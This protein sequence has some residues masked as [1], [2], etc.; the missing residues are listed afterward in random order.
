MNN[1]E[2]FNRVVIH[3]RKQGRKSHSSNRLRRDECK[4]R[5]PDGLCCA[6]GC[7]IDDEHYR[8]EMEAKP[9][10]GG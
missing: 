8:P 6:V 1:Q 2:I 7:L 9:V 3:L 10:S 4:Y 5:A